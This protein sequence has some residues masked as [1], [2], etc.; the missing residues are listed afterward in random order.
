MR[1]NEMNKKAALAEVKKLRDTIRYY[2][3]AYHVLDKSL[4]SDAALDSLKHQL[5]LLE[6][7]Y[8]DLITP[9][10][11]T[12]R[13]GGVPLKEFKKVRH[14]I[15]MLSI[16]DLFSAEELKDWW[17]YVRKFSIFKETQ[18]R[19]EFF[20]EPKID[21]L[22][23]DLI[24]EKGI[25]KR[26]STRGDGHIGE[27]VTANVR[28]I[29]AVPLRLKLYQPLFSQKVEKQVQDSLD[30]GLLEIRGEAYLS[31][32]DF[33]Q[34]NRER[35]QKGEK[36]YANSRNLAAG[37]IRQL[38]AEVTQS[39]HLSFLAWELVSDVGEVKH[40]QEHQITKA[41]GFKTDLGKICHSLDEVVNFWK[42][43]Q[44]DRENL[45]YPIDGVVVNINDNQIF[46][47]LGVAGKSPRG[48]RALKFPPEQAITKVK[49]I[50]I[51]IGRTGAATP[52]ALLEPVNVGGTVVSRATL[53]NADEIQ[54]LGI[55]IGDTVIVGRAG[56][57]IPEVL[58]VLV[59][60]RTGKEKSFK[61]PKN[62]PV[63]GTPLVREE[64][65]VIWRCPNPNCPAR[66][67][68][69]LEHFVSRKAFDIKGLGEQIIQQLRK[70]KLISQPADIF[71]LHLS[72]LMGLEGFQKKSAQ[73]L[74][75]SIEK[76]KTINFDKFL[77]ALGI[78]QVGQKTA[79]FLSKYFKNLDNLQKASQDELASLP[80]IGSKTAQEIV[81]WFQRKTNLKLIQKLLERGV[82]IHYV[83]T[84]Y[85]LSWEGVK[86]VLTGKLNHF[87]REEAI[88]EIQ[89]RGGEIQNSISKKVK[90]LIC[91]KDP[92]SKL[93]K[94]KKAGVKVIDENQFLKMLSSTKNGIKKV[95]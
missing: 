16:E 38:K 92:G 30:H 1:K 67:R 50:L 46:H 29:E 47:A 48:I 36:P 65:Q 12:Q 81:A 22:A 5:W 14:S 11:P 91:G 85:K 13:V 93:S 9:D 74:I 90:F 75:Q 78:P 23:I 95:S 73:N 28:T 77:F 17:N 49:N 34:I 66:R 3:Y 52:V 51:Q 60:M 43:M 24:Y 89:K 6:Q 70:E 45:P 79:Q 42:Q 27:D 37:S 18:W 7:Q 71:S 61:M 76:S 10:S 20:C 80:D 55:K 57:V 25:L 40:S 68:N 72:D 82:K 53:H 21:G 88:A 4:I 44:E 39:R 2:R 35:I 54:R 8:P 58:K 33:Q 83:H 56:D 86:F 19:E 62:C 32:E 15:P 26:A 64:G 87:S 69:F 31:K 63:C 84:S 59:R 41:L 94:A